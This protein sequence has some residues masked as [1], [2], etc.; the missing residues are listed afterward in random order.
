MKRCYIWMNAN[1]V[2]MYVKKSD[3]GT[4]AKY[5]VWFSEEVIL[6]KLINFALRSIW[7]FLTRSCNGFEED[8]WYAQ[9]FPEVLSQIK[10]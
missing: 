10:K 3:W 2:E 9:I 8:E 1:H 7:I 6:S 4:G 5:C